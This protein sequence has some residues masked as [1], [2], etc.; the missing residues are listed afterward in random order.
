MNCRIQATGMVY[1]AN[2]LRIE[3]AGELDVVFSSCTT[4]FMSVNVDLFGS[5]WLSKSLQIRVRKSPAAIDYAYLGIQYKKSVQRLVMLEKNTK[6]L[7]L[8]N[9]Y[10]F[11]N[12]RF[13]SIN[14]FIKR[15]LTTT[16]YIDNKFGC[17]PAHRSMENRPESYKAITF[18]EAPIPVAMARPVNF[19]AFSIWL[20]A[21][22]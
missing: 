13:Q 8:M 14:L 6:N 21:Y 9:P 5:L 4:V 2:S 12:S 17:N 22:R 7:K 10:H 3:V 16:E 19:I 15:M 18:I 1:K 20:M 11:R